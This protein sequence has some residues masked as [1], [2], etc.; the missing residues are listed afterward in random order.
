MPS[1]Q[2]SCTKWFVFVLVLM[3]ASCS[4]ILCYGMT[5]YTTFFFIYFHYRLFLVFSLISAVSARVTSPSQFNYAIRSFQFTFL[6]I[7]LRRSVFFFSFSL[8]LF[9][10]FSRE[11]LAFRLTCKLVRTMIHIQSTQFRFFETSICD[12]L[13]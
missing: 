5:A 1:I 7:L 4:T 3:H 12:E 13:F 6:W 8:L 9:R 11:S 2:R 10:Q